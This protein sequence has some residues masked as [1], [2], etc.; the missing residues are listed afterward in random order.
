MTWMTEQLWNCFSGHW[1]VVYPHLLQ[2]G[3]NMFMHSHTLFGEV[4]IAILQV[5]APR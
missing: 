4:M 5:R 1:Y 3:C 2:V